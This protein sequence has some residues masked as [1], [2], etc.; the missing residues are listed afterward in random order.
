V[1]RIL[2]LHDSDIQLVERP[3]TGACFRFSIPLR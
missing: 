2:L 1:R 3:Q